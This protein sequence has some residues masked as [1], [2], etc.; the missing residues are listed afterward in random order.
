MTK[1]GQYP[2]IVEMTWRY[3]N[4]GTAEGGRQPVAGSGSSEP[5]QPLTFDVE[6]HVISIGVRI[7]LQRY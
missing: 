4:L 3:Y 2:I 1:P 7:P 6:S 5:V